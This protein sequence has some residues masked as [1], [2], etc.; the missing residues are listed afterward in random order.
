MAFGGIESGIYKVLVRCR[1]TRKSL[2]AAY[3]MLVLKRCR[4]LGSNRHLTA[5]SL[6]QK[7]PLNVVVAMR[8]ARAVL[9]RI[10]AGIEAL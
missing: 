8:Y 4:L 7:W 3:G 5:V 1:S 6:S 9:Q 2:S 10:N